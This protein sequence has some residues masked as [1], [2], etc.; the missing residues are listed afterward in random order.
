[1]G[2]ITHMKISKPAIN[3]INLWLR[4][5][6]LFRKQQIKITNTK[7]NTNINIQPKQQYIYNK[8]DKPRFKK[9]AWTTHIKKAHTMSNNITKKWLMAIS[10]KNKSDNN[11]KNIEVNKLEVEHAKEQE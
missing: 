5:Q 3:N 7:T 6:L 11:N 2:V 9:G 10:I 1:M 4:N 8:C